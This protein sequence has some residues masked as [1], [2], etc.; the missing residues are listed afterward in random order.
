M[1]LRFAKAQQSFA[2][3]LGAAVFTMV[4]L[5]ASAPVIPVA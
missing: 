2:A 4:L 5:V 3:F 1:S